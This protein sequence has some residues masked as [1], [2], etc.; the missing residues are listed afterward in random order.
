M[1]IRDSRDP[2]TQRGR[3]LFLSL[4]CAG[5]HAVAGTTAQGKVAPRDLTNV[6]S[7]ETIAGVV[8]MNEEN[9]FRWIKNPQ[10]LKP[11]TAMPN[12]NLDDET[13]GAIVQWLLTL[14]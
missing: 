10:A 2:A 7:F 8:P 14:K 3:E 11:G 12:L 5:C 1:C 4:A 13:V 6:A 9:L